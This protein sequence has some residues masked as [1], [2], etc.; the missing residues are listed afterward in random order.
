M[1]DYEPTTTTPTTCPTCGAE[2]QE[3]CP[4]AC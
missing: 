2:G 3:A 1:P 4:S